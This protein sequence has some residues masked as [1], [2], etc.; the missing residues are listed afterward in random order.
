MRTMAVATVVTVPIALLPI[1]EKVAPF[2][3]TIGVLL[4]GGTYL[5]LNRGARYDDEWQPRP[6]EAESVG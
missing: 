6:E 5:Y 3:W 4:A 2:S 1:F